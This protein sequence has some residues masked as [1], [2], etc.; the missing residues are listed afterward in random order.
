[1]VLEQ[2]PPQTVPVPAEQSETQVLLLQYSVAWQV[3]VQFPQWAE[4]SGTQEPLQ[5]SMSA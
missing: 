3:V 2:W 1:M 4:S 5:S